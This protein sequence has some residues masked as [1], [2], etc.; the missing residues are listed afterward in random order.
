MVAVALPVTLGTALFIAAGAQALPNRTLF[1]LRPLV[2]LGLIS[3]PLYLWHWP[4]LSLLGLMGID[5]GPE[6]RVLRATVVGLTVIAAMLTYHLIELPL[7]RRKDLR[8]IGVRLVALLGCAALA[9]IAI[10]RTGGLPQR[11][12]MAHNPL[13]WEPSMRFENRCAALY[14]Q[15]ADL[16][17]HALCI[18]N[19]YSRVPS[20]VILG[21]SH[22]NMFVPGII[23]ANPNSSI[24]QIGAS[25]CAYLRNTRFWTDIHRSWRDRCPPLMAVAYRGITPAT[26]VVVLIARLPMYV[27]SPA[28]YAT[29]FD[30]VSPKH[31]ES[32]DFPGE[33]PVDT[34]RRA[35]MREAGQLLEAGLEVVLVMPVP[36]LNF[37]PR[38]CVRIRPLDRWR[39]LPGEAACSVSRASVEAVQASS[40]DL[41]ESVARSLANPRLHV[42][43][44][45][46][47]LCDVKICR[48][49]VGGKLM[50]RDDNHLSVEG[51]RYVW[52][53]I[54]PSVIK[55]IAAE[56]SYAPSH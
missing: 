43:D 51:S 39:A 41:V 46:E 56:E 18:R 10:A 28:E 4:P 3:Y 13:N 19:N 8:P 20:I 23:A 53:R 44:P 30:F 15:P 55:E 37:S 42:V 2:Y 33:S 34:Y 14:G 1:S 36:A 31:F 17:E 29:T 38:S 47:A 54:Q 49:V 7:R 6:G 50:Y 9:G 12:T 35:L 40:R 16:R 45:M 26:R 24:L 32:P 5:R 22:A 27:A 11:T 52:A 25:A 48:A 21:D